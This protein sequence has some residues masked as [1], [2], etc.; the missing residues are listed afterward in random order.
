MTVVT[1]KYKTG[2]FP[3]KFLPFHRGHMNAILKAS[4]QCET[5]YVCVCE[6]RDYDKVCETNNIKPMP[7]ALRLRWVC[8]ELEDFAHIKVISIDCAPEDSELWSCQ[9][10]EIVPDID[11]MFVGE[12]SYKDEFI[13]HYP[14][15]DY[16][17]YDPDRLE[18]DI[19]ATEIRDNPYKHWDF[20]LGSVRP[21]FAK[22]VLLVGTESCGKSSLTKM[23][24]KIFHTS[25]ARE[26]G[27][28]YADKYLGGN[29]D[30]ITKEDFF[31]IAYEQRQIE[32]DAI[33]N[34]NKITF[35]DTDSLITQYYCEQFFGEF[36]DD[37]YVFIDPSRYDMVLI[38]KPDVK[39]VG[40]GTRFLGE[41]KMREKLHK[42]VLQMYIDRGYTNIYE[43]GGNYEER[44][45]V[46]KYLSKRLILATPFEE[47]NIIINDTMMLNIV[48]MGD[49]NSVR[50]DYI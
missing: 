23:L 31:R 10:H 41:Q 2:V 5:L 50:I 30:C 38:M 20:M 46:A 8:Q 25:W 7:L 39:W 32:D 22:K 37:L 24:A 34:A 16:I 13:R 4:T 19:S 14:D 21:H 15:V 43:L 35:F 9:L 40:D 33:R 47:S 42:K 36:N 11:V 18:V 45:E 26:E 12:V 17:V 44:L 27:R 6:G 49:Y 28:Y 1:L 29:W 3:S 48:N